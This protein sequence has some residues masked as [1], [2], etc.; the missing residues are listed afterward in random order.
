MFTRLALAGIQPSMLTVQYR[1]HPVIAHFPSTR[2]YSNMLKS[3]PTSKDRPTPTGF[4]WP[5]P[6]R[7]PPQHHLPESMTPPGGKGI[8]PHAPSL[9]CS[10]QNVPVA[11]VAVGE[12]DQGFF[13]QRTSGNQ[14]SY[15]NPREAE[16]LMDALASFL[17]TG[18]LAPADI[19][20]P[21]LPTLPS[22][23]LFQ[24]SHPLVWLQV[25]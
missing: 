5:N 3:H 13:E 19:G 7:P 20:T 22:P 6:V 4:P 1:M 8:C 10:T 23:A 12:G 18:K 9:F 25:L 24:P 14:T 21:I 2:F 15:M 11:F 16:H 17:Q